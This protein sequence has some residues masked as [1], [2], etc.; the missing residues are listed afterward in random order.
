MRC[1]G[2]EVRSRNDYI[3]GTYL[4]LLQNATIWNVWNNTDHYLVLGC[5]HRAAP[6]AHSRYLSKRIRLNIKLP[7]NP[8][9][10]DPLFDDL[11]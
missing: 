11:R 7:T 6:T 2:R 1:G 4:R 10:F 3:M 9:G 8:D 5:L